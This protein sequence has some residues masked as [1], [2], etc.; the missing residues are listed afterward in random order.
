[1]TVVVNFMRYP[2]VKKIEDQIA[3]DRVIAKIKVARFI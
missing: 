1:V 2:A 3:F